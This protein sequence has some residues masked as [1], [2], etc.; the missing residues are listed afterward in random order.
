MNDSQSTH[1]PDLLGELR[2]FIALGEEALIFI[3]KEHQAL[4]GAGNYE[5]F[6]FYRRRKDL[7]VRLNPMINNIKHWR[8]IWQQISPGER[9]SHLEVKD[10]IQK[11]QTLIFKFLQLDR[12]NQQA[13]LRR[14]LVPANHVN[15]CASPPSNYVSNLYRRYNH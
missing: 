6:E 7:L 13:L 12:E 1:I 15:A 14:G 3:S 9:A 5:P 2:S 4:V 8:K 11:I 10:A